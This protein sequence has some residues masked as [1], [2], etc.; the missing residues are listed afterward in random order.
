MRGTTPLAMMHGPRSAALDARYPTPV[1]FLTMRNSIIVGIAFAALSAC[2]D[3]DGGAGAGGAAS[4]SASSSSSGSVT[5]ASSS[6]GPASDPRRCL[7]AQDRVDACGIHLSEHEG[8]GGGLLGG[9]LVGVD[10]LDDDVGEVNGDCGTVAQC[11][12]N[13]ILISTCQELAN[14]VL[15][16]ATNYVSC[17]EY[18]LQLKVGLG[19]QDVASTE[20]G[21][22]GSRGNLDIGVGGGVLP[23]ASSGQTGQGGA[24]DVGVGGKL[25]AGV[26]GGGGPVDLGD[27]GL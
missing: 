12:A 13:C 17:I 4:A 6:T 22:G 16:L 10:L 21:S 19:G 20:T 15:G 3:N 8:A 1:T 9:S 11:A 27:I 14:A 18:C 23:G 25:D 2:K 24:L 7:D 26:G 5:A